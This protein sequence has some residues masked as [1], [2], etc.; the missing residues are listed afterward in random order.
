M[1]LAQELYIN[2]YS[3]NHFEVSSIFN[4][5]AYLLPSQG[6]L[7]ESLEYHKNALKIRKK[8]LGK[9]HTDVAL[10]YN[11]LAMTYSRF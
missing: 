11:N 7:K 10:S 1:K 4:N 3:L 5:V 6:K 8:C 9:I 2:Y